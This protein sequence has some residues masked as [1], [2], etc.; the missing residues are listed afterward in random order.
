M[1]QELL[2]Y[3]R[4]LLSLIRLSLCLSHSLVLQSVILQFL[5]PYSKNF[6]TVDGELGSGVLLNY[7]QNDLN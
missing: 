2:N 4:S 7:M 5:H 1:C 3:T 6:L